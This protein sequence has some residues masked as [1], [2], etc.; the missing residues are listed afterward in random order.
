MDDMDVQ[1][2]VITE[3]ALRRLDRFEQQ[4]LGPRRQELLQ[5][6]PGASGNGSR[7]GEVG[8]SYERMFNGGE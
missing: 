1:R 2:G 3:E 8:G 7:R 4:V 5:A 6:A